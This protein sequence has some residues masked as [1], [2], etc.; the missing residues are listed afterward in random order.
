LLIK[1]SSHVSSE[2]FKKK[3]EVLKDLRHPRW[4]PWLPQAVVVVAY[5]AF[6]ASSGLS[7]L[8]VFFTS[9][10]LLVT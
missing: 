2:K 10:A 9:S 5:M 6:F 3:D 1:V 7:V 4:H 8:L